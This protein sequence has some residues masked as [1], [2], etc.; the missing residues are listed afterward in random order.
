M[1]ALSELIEVAKVTALVVVLML[2]ILAPA[3][4]A[5]WFVTWVAS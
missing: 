5:A 2:L 3:V 1:A 4:V